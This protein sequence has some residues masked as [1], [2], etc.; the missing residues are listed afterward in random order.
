MHFLI[1]DD[2]EASRMVLMAHLKAYGTC[3]VCGNGA[4]AVEAVAK[5]LDSGRPY[6]VIFMDIVMPGPDGHETLEKIHALEKQAGISP[7][8][9][10]KAIMVTSMDDEDNT[11]TALFED[12]VSAYLIKPV[13]KIELEAKLAALG[14]LPA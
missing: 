8:N 2:D 11:M 1:V 3:D 5:S 12:G 7:E 10:A 6:D 13:A 9:R 14:I 4:L